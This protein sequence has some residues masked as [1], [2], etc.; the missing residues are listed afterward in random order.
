MW[1]PPL[2]LSEEFGKFG[3]VRSEEEEFHFCY[4]CQRGPGVRVQGGTLIGPTDWLWPRG[5][6]REAHERKILMVLF[7]PGFCS[8]LSWLQPFAGMEGFTTQPV[9]GGPAAGQHYLGAC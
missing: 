8:L 4:L 1:K 9:A 6:E 5:V 2:K 3:L 7:V